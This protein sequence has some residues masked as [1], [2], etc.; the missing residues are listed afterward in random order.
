[1]EQQAS[2]EG[3]LDQRQLN[4]LTPHAAVRLW[5]MGNLPSPST[6]PWALPAAL[7]PHHPQHWGRSYSC[8]CWDPWSGK[9][10]QHW[11]HV[12]EVAA[13]MS[14]ACF[15]NGGH[16]LLKITLYDELFTGYRDRG[17]PEKR[18]KNSLKKTLDTCHVNHHKWSTLAANRQAWRHTVHQVVSTFKDSH[19]AYPREKR[20]IRKIQG[21]SAVRLDKTFKCSRCD[22]TWLSCIGL[23][24]HQHACSRRGQPPS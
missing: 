6:I 12:A 23:V 7:S 9:N 22:R 21:A 16:R 17:T 18:F 20:R 15:Q 2:G 4:R 3:C 10:H 11:G 13:M 5:V 19:R 1:M 24:N 8:E 14:R